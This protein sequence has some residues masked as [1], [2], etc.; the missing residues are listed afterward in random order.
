MRWQRSL[1][2]VRRL[3]ARFKTGVS[4][5]GQWDDTVLLPKTSFPMRSGA[6]SREPLIAAN[7]WSGLYHEQRSQREDGEFV[8]HDGPPFANGPAHIGHALNKVKQ[9]VV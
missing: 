9:P 1:L 7:C 4:R 2:I 3:G 5:S 6:S 8:L